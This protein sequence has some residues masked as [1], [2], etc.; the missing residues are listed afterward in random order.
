M[1][2][3][4]KQFVDKYDIKSVVKALKSER[5]TQGKFVNKFESNLKK[6]FGSKYC[7]VVSNGTAALHLAVLALNIKK[8]NLVLTTPLSFLA[9]SNCAF[10]ANL[11]PHFIDINEDN[12]TI[13]TK[14]LE[15]EIKVLRKKRKKIGVIIATDYAGHPCDWKKI[16]Q[17]SKKYK[18]PVI[19]DNCHAI[20][21][22]YYSDL[23]YAVKYSDIATHSYHAVKNIT[24]G[25]GGAVFTNDQRIFDKINVLRTHG[26]VRS[27]EKF[28]TIGK[29]YYEMQD[30]G[31]NYRLTDIQCALGISQLKKLKKFVIRRREIAKLYNQAFSKNDIFRIPTESKNIK[32]AFHIYPLLINFDKIKITKKKFFEELE[33]YKI[34]LQVHYIPIHFQPFY[35]KKLNYK[36]GDYPITE[37]FYDMEV[38][39]PIHYSLKDNQIKKIIKIIIKICR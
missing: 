9:T 38:S 20:G 12:Y 35:K 13:D 19:N 11:I 23:K 29:W 5:I 32:S 31:F 34:Y 4:G 22:K 15:K 6:Y 24:T 25:E 37:R 33:N 21:S 39:L 26:V 3:Y 1:I 18:I 10:Y 36:K 16:R 30:L 8:G 27:E 14:Q 7:S 2:T 17:I 28:R